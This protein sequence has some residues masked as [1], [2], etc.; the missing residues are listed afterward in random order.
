MFSNYLKT[1]E[2]RTQDIIVNNNIFVALL[3]VAMKIG[4]IQ[5][6]LLIVIIYWKMEDSQFW[7]DFFEALVEEEIRR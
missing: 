7:D 1:P 4:W 6:V 3:F 2:I 5:K